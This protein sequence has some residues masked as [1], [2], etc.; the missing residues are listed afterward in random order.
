MINVLTTFL[1]VGFD[2]SRIENLFVESVQ[3]HG[4]FTFEQILMVES[5]EKIRKRVLISATFGT[6]FKAKHVTKIFS[7]LRNCKLVAP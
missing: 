2:K 4:Q 1:P 7:D 5:T 6:A 3:D